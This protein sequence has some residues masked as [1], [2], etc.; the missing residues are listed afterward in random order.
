MLHTTIQKFIYWHCYM[1]RYILANHT[2]SIRVVGTTLRS[3]YHTYIDILVCGRSSPH[4][5]IRVVQLCYIARFTV[6]VA[7]TTS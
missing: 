1:H 5:S 6:L 2:Y 7:W 3:A 4:F